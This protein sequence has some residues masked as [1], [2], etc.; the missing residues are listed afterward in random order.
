MNRSIT[1]RGTQ[2]ADVLSPPRHRRRKYA[3]H[4]AGDGGVNNSPD[5]IT[6]SVCRFPGIAI[7]ASPGQDFPTAYTTTGTTYVWTSPDQPLSVIDKQV[8]P[9]PNPAVSCPFCGATA[10]LY[11]SKGSGNAIP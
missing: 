2:T 9:V 1:H 4:D 5:R 3:R 10:Y 11:G 6:C 8:V 7:T